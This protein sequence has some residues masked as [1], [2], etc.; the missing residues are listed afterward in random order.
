MPEYALWTLV[1]SLAVLSF[2]MSLKIADLKHTIKL[3]SE[4]ND[5]FIKEIAVIENDKNKAV[6]ALSESH[7]TIVKE[8]SQRY[9]A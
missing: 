7:N 9:E 1:I 4:E 8:L 3:F 6:S 5:R 2:G